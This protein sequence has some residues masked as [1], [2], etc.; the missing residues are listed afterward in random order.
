MMPTIT[1][2]SEYIRFTVPPCSTSRDMMSSMPPRANRIIQPAVRVVDPMNSGSTV[3][4]TSADFHRLVLRA[5][6]QAIG[7]PKRQAH[8]GHDDRDADR[9]DQH[10]PVERIIEEAQVVRRRHRG[11]HQLVRVVAVEAVARQEGQRRDQHHHHH[12]AGG[13]EQGKRGA[14]FATFR[15]AECSYP[16]VV[17]IRD[18]LG[19]HR[20]IR[21]HQ[22]RA[23]SRGT[24]IAHRP[25]RTAAR[26]PPWA[27]SP[28]A[29][30]IPAAPMAPAVAFMYLYAASLSGAFFGMAMPET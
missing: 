3:S 25:C 5:R 4:T 13:A 26:C 1:A 11:D 15:H 12:Q 19:Y 8:D 7:S 16:P 22:L 24:P 6:R 28:Y 20:I 9:G 23:W 27:D 10:V 21:R 18:R 29:R 17:Q 14:R 2:D 30:Q